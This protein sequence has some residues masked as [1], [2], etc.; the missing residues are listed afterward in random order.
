MLVVFCVHEAN[1]VSV[2]QRRA[3][4]TQDE[5]E[6]VNKGHITEEYSGHAKAFGIFPNKMVN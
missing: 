1:L 3:R 6:E 2:Q 4:V 5:I